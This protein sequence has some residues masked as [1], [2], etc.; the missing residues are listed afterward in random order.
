M[1]SSIFVGL[2]VHKATV[3]VAVAEGV[4]GG[5]VRSLG[6]VRNTVSEI[7]KM[8]ERLA[9]RDRRLKFCYEAAARA[10]MGFIACS[11]P[12]V[13]TVRSLRPR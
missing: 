13:T 10:A 1:D 12:L 6:T 7:G 2:D 9:G 8:V 4:W 3:S 5:E 11:R